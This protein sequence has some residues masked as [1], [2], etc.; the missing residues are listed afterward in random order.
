MKKITVCVLCSSVNKEG[1][2]VFCVDKLACRTEAFRIGAYEDDDDA[3]TRDNG[4]RGLVRTKKERRR[5]SI[6]T[7]TTT[8]RRGRWRRFFRA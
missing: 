4:V 1:H 2:E 8:R 6:I 5:R 7:T 3:E